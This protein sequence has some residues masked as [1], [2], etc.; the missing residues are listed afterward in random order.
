MLHIKTLGP[1]TRRLE[2][3]ARRSDLD[4]HSISLFVE[5]P[6]GSLSL[7]LARYSSVLM[8][9]GGIGVT[10]LGSLYN[11]LLRDHYLG[12]RTMRHMRLVWSVRDPQL[13]HSLYTDVRDAD[14]AHTDL[15]SI[16]PP[17]ASP[18]FFSTRDSLVT[19]DVRSAS[20]ASRVDGAPPTPHSAAGPQ[21][22]KRNAVVPLADSVSCAFHVTAA[23]AYREPEADASSPRQRA[24]RRYNSNRWEEWVQQGRPHLAD[25]FQLMQQALTAS[26]VSEHAQLER[27]AVLACGP[28]ALIEEVRQLCCSRS[29]SQLCFDLHEE[30]FEW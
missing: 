24:M 7:P 12:E 8:V 13:I 3:L 14:R 16:A 6:Y 9:A 4:A 2:Q 21:R 11:E 23:N 28:A 10:P 25:S 15:P 22:Y 5:G 29:T 27:C 30:T 19:L 1:W 17:P 26:G 20:T 18:S